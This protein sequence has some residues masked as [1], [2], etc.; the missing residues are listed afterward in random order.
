M[1]KDVYRLAA[2]A[3]VLIAG[4]LI[5]AAYYIRAQKAE[6]A[7]AVAKQARDNA[8]VFV[9]PHS[10][11]FG[12]A[13]AKVTVVEFL[14]PECESCRAMFPFVKRLLAQ[15]DGRVR[16]VVRYMPFHPNSSYAVSA[17]EA[18]GEQGRFAE[19]LETLFVNQPLWGDHHAPKPELIPEFARQ[20]GLDMVSFGRSLNSSAHKAIL[21]TDLADG[22]K[23]GVTG[24]P[25]FFVNE[26]L[27]EPLEYETFLAL[28]EDELAK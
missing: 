24:T 15:Y 1:K 14:D 28:I 7:E 13:N 16:L 2:I 19:M 4:M 26:R 21:E 23:L 3:A 8:A 9:R 6:R 22:K 20:I 18:A 17:L 27:L 11:G 5:V 12:P 10:R 25:T